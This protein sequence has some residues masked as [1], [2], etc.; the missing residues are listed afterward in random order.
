MNSIYDIVGFSL[1]YNPKRLFS[2]LN[3]QKGGNTK[4]TAL[5]LF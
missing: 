4:I 2:D 1:F 5:K 3:K